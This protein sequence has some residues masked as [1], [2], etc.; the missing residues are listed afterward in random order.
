[1]HKKHLILF[2]NNILVQNPLTE[3]NRASFILGEANFW[4]L[5][6][7]SGELTTEASEQD[8]QSLF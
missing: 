8:L 1:M 4:L 7:F 5:G 3:R 6:E 2:I